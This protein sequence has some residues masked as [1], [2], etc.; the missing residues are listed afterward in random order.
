MGECV[1]GRDSPEPHRMDTLKSGHLDS[2]THL[3]HDVCII[4]GNF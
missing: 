2:Q 4:K 3:L 1:D